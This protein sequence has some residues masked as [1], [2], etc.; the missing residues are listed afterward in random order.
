MPKMR[1]HRGLAKRVKRTKTG[2]LKRWRAYTS[3][4]SHNKTT[5]QKRQLRKASVVSPSDYR[6]VKA[7]IPQ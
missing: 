4:L 3:H 7:M 1:T 5:K 2:S 6:R